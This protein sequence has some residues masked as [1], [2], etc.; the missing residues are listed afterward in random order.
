MRQPQVFAVSSTVLLI[1]LV[2]RCSSPPSTVDAP[3]NTVSA[4]LAAG[5]ISVRLTARY[6]YFEMSF[7]DTIVGRRAAGKNRDVERENRAA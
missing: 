5:E 2:E 6:R 7:A 4:P 1:N 3:Q